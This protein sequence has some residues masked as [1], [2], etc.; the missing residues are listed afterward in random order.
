[1]AGKYQKRGLEWR[2]MVVERMAQAKNIS[3]LAAELGINRSQLYRWWHELRPDSEPPGPGD[4]RSAAELRKELR[5]LKRVLAEK[6]L[7]VDFFKGALHKVE[8]R[9]QKS[10]KA[11]GKASTSR[12]EA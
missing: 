8:A 11:G 10:E 4:E 6:T 3:D 7:E 12:S 5:Q 2:Q 9:R 1:M